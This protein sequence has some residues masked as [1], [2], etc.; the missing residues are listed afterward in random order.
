[1]AMTAGC[2]ELADILN[3][4][5]E[6][7]QVLTDSHQALSE[8]LTRPEE[9]RMGEINADMLA[10]NEQLAALDDRRQALLEDSDAPDMAALVS[11]CDVAQSWASIGSR[12]R[13]LQEPMRRNQQVIGRI[14]EKLS[15][16]LSVLRGEDDVIQAATYSAS[17]SGQGKPPASSRHLG[18]A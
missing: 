7:I 16:Q 10:A 5:L 13:E 12:L 1:M 3:Q 8:Q 4:M 9:D 15:E 6:Q 17:G 2:D 18:D 14:S 11:A